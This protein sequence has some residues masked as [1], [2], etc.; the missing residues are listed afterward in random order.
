MVKTMLIGKKRI[1]SA[2]FDS[3]DVVIGPCDASEIRLIN[4]YAKTISGLTA[5]NPELSLEASPDGSD[6][7]WI[8]TGLSVVPSASANVVIEGTEEVNLLFS[9]VRIK[10]SFDAFSAGEF[11]IY[12]L[13]RSS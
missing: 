10:L 2:D 11:D 9:R 1:S 3:G 8:D 13:G 7:V 6:D 12:L 5:T 4:V